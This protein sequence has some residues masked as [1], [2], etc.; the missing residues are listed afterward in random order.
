MLRRNMTHETPPLSNPWMDALDA[1]RL[2]ETP[3]EHWISLFPAAPFFGLRWAFQDAFPAMSM[4]S[5]AM[6]P[7]TMVGLSWRMP[8]PVQGEPRQEV[9]V[10][11]VVLEAADATAEALPSAEPTPSEAVVEE[12]EAADPGPEQPKPRPKR[13]R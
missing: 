4:W 1:A 10:E 6:T 2:A 7:Q 12:A 9:Q 11:A 13:G 5:A 3:L 8:D